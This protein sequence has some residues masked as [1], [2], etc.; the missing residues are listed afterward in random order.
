MSLRIITTELLTDLSEEQQEVLTGGEFA[1]PQQFSGNFGLSETSFEQ[2]KQVLNTIS[3]SGSKGS[4][5]GGYSISELIKT[6]G[7]N[8]IGLK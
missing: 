8:S 4:V 3:S 6:S 5:A 7:V 1:F 2:S